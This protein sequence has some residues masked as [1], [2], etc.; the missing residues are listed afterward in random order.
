VSVGVGGTVETALTTA[1]TEITIAP[2]C[3]G[4]WLVAADPVYLVRSDAVA[5][6]GAVPA[7]ERFRVPAGT[8]IPLIR[9][10]RRTLV[11]A[12][13]GTSTAWLLGV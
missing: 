3:A 1:C 5:D 4:V 8:L 6:G 10:G 13:T 9:A 11:A 2:G 12:V 7:S